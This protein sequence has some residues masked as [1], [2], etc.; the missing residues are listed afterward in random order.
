[1]GNLQVWH[2]LS[3]SFVV[4]MPQSFGGPAYQA[5]IPTLVDAKDMPNAIALNSIQ[6]NLARVIGP[7]L[8]GITLASLGA[9]WCFSLNG[10]SFLAVIISLLLLHIRNIPART[11]ASMLHTMKEGFRFIRSQEGME[12][13]IIIAFLM[14][15]LGI[16]LLTFLPVVATKVFSG[17]AKTYTWLLSISGAGAVC[18]ALIVAWLGN[19]RNKGQIALSMLVA[20]G[21]LMAGFGLSK[22]FVFS[23]VMLFLA[24]GVLMA[25][26]AMISS[27][28][29][30]IAPDE[31]RG[32]VMSV[33]NVAFRGGMPIGSLISGALVKSLG[34]GMVLA[35]N[36][37]LLV[38]I[39]LYF[40]VV[41]RRVAAL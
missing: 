3:L 39:G 8:G 13:L 28:V 22:S 7:T 2:I 41:H 30:L 32:R 14:T 25:S 4:G 17:D 10:L 34:V 26:F 23:C 27:L 36:G 11:G 5:L 24:G 15:F 38:C 19:V 31:M 6:F 12:S 33:Y 29:Q 21:G 16:P 18:G 37:V 20:L 9:A 1:M 35:G 40:L